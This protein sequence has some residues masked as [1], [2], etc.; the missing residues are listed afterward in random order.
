MG[1][2][3]VEEENII[4]EGSERK[5]Q[6]MDSFLGDNQSP[7]DPSTLR[8]IYN[9]CNGLEINDFLQKKLQQQKNKQKRDIY[10]EKPNIRKW[11]GYLELWINGQ[12]ISFA[13]LK[14]KQNGKII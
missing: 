5:R 11:E 12:E 10:K 2:T 4:P 13:C 8:I 7:V 9:N 1:S 3:P 6:G 14:P